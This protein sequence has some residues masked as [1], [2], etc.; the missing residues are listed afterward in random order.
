M[1]LPPVVFR[2]ITGCCPAIGGE[3]QTRYT[4]KYYPPPLCFAMQNI[5]E[6]ARSDGGVEYH[7]KSIRMLFLTACRG[8]RNVVADKRF[9]V[10]I[11][12]CPH[13]FSTESFCP[14]CSAFALYYLWQKS[15]IGCDSAKKQMDLFFLLSSCTIFVPI[16]R[17]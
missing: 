15:G 2:N 14:F 10:N 11:Q 3:E 7:Q 4:G 1:K 6:V 17:V 13:E 5:G 16:K 9:I 12:V 8:D